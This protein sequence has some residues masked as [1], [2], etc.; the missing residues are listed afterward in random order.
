MFIYA[1]SDPSIIRT[2]VL[3]C[4]SLEHHLRFESNPQP[5]SLSNTIL[6]LN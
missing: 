1:D 2:P 6:L 5:Q 4:V 3:N